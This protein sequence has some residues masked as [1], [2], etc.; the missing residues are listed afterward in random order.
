MTTRTSTFSLWLTIT[1]VALLIAGC[2][3]ER[4]NGTNLS[5]PTLEE[6]YVR[7]DK[8]VRA[9]LSRPYGKMTVPAELFVDLIQP[10]HTGDPVSMMVSASA[11]AGTS[12]SLITLRVP[13]IARAPARTEVL[14]SAEASPVISESLKY[15]MPPLPKGRYHF[16]AVIEFT[17]DREGA[18]PLVLSESLFVDV[19]A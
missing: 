7:R 5:R 1:T 18:E 11:M 13:E 9:R 10:A 12:S 16:V 17:P 19:R 14:W 4:Q 8:P 2:G 3:S 15:A 6:T